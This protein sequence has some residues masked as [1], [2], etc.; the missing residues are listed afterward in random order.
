MIRFLIKM[1]VVVIILFVAMSIP[2]LETA[3]YILIAIA[4]FL[5]CVGIAL[6]LYFENKE[7]KR[8]EES[9]AE[10]SKQIKKEK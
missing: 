9:E 4:G 10:K 5:L 7:K 6:Y 1:L 8:I 2:A 3:L